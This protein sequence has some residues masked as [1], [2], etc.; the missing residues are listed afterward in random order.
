[1]NWTRTT[2]MGQRVFFSRFVLPIL[3]VYSA[4]WSLSSS[5]SR[6]RWDVAKSTR[7]AYL[8]K[9]E[10]L[11]RF[12]VG[13][14][15]AQSGSAQ[16]NPLYSFRVSSRESCWSMGMN[17]FAPPPLINSTLSEKFLQ[18]HFSC[19]LTWIRLVRY[20]PNH[21]EMTELALAIVEGKYGQ[22]SYF[23]KARK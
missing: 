4:T 3:V 5:L 11:V 19:K 9:A 18:F 14:R 17:Y 1:M 10:T 7:S 21:R 22:L 20:R 23:W 8:K 6:L 12:C 16:E 15:V 2:R 13:Y